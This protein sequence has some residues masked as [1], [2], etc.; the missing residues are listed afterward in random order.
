MKEGKLRFCFMLFG[1]ILL[2]V[3]TLLE[4]LRPDVFA[5]PYNYF[6]KNVVLLFGGIAYVLVVVDVIKRFRW[7]ALFFVFVIALGSVILLPLYWAIFYLF[8]VY[9][10]KSEKTEPL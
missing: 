6:I 2:S 4:Y 9:E 10:Y 1:N 3:Y 5:F 7:Q 8:F